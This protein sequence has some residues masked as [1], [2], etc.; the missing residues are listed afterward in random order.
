MKYVEGNRKN[1]GNVGDVVNFRGIIQGLGTCKKNN[2]VCVV[3][4]TV[5]NKN[6]GKT[7]KHDHIWIQVTKQFERIINKEQVGKVLFME[8]IVESY[9]KKDKKSGERVE[10]LG[11][12]GKI[13]KDIIK[14]HK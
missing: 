2:T 9:T 5:F 11:I 4:V 13:I 7:T 10:Q 8:G 6:T 14:I 1:I 12:E 3:N